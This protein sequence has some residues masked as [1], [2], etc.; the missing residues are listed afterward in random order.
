[1]QV[2]GA[3]VRFPDGTTYHGQV[4]CAE[5][6]F[7]PHGFGRMV[8]TDGTF[9]DGCFSSGKKHGLGAYTS[10]LGHVRGGEWVNDHIKHGTEDR[11]D[12][13]FYEGGFKNDLWHG[14]GR[15]V[16]PG[17]DVYDGEWAAGKMH[18]QGTYTWS[19]GTAYQ[20]GWKDGKRHGRGQTTCR[21]GCTYEA[22]WHAN[23]RVNGILTRI[24]PDGTSA[25]MYATRRCEL[26][27]SE[28]DRMAAVI[29][30]LVRGWIAR[31]LVRQLRSEQAVLISAEQAMRAHLIELERKERRNGI[32][33]P[34]KATTNTIE[35]MPPPADDSAPKWVHKERSRHPRKPPAQKAPKAWCDE[36]RQGALKKQM[37][38]ARHQRATTANAAAAPSAPSCIDVLDL[39][40]KT[41]RKAK[42]A[43]RAKIQNVQPLA[44]CNHL[45]VITGK[46]KHGQYACIKGYVRQLLDGAWRATYAVKRAEDGEGTDGFYVKIT[47]ELQDRV[48]DAK[49]S[50]EAPTRPVVAVRR[51]A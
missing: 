44:N 7:Q 36:V 4:G 43:L 30:R 38:R 21:D 48:T 16:S 3:T 27:I 10:Q 18:G 22:T 33:P 41:Q 29:Q 23:K 31:K 26:E 11:V 40:G 24:S 5:R 15:M 19:D 14:Q 17:G 6:G 37:D 32:V 46:G 50:Q 28:A 47:A 42:E 45:M 35:H 8:W 20:G 9:F 39:H 12:G 2:S 1:M 51:R 25:R 13:T 34:R 49:K